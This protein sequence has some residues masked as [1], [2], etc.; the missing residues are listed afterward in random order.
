MNVKR[1][2]ALILA[3]MAG[4]GCI[5]VSLDE[6]IILPPS[7]F[8]PQVEWDPIQPGW[9][10]EGYRYEMLEIERPD[11]AL[12]RGVWVMHPDNEVTVLYF[13]GN[14]DTISKL[15]EH[16]IPHLAG[17][18]VNLVMFDR[19]GYGGS[20]GSPSLK[21]SGEDAVQT[22]DFVRAMVDGKL[23]VHGFSLGSF[24]AGAVAE[25]R[26]VDGLVLE[27][28]ATNVD[29]WSYVFCPWYQRLI[30]RL[31]IGEEMRVADNL[32]VVRNQAA[33]L[34]LLVGSRDSQT[35]ARFSEKLFREAV[36][37]RKKLH[38][39]EGWGHNSLMAHP[40]FEAV[41]GEFLAE[42]MDA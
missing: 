24:E 37:D 9:I 42:L 29:E 26:P 3:L 30:V 33:P 20:S 13:P 28:S 10:P 22:Y 18:K 40:D 36:A 41:Y 32:R 15:G 14:M 6:T 31:E 17:Y 19:R 23:I 21:S 35:P 38:V 12:G 2:P 1:L 8:D 34:L 25:R 27:S 16:L 11:D 39:F 7:S 5:P 4:A